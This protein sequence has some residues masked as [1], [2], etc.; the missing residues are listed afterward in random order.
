M[1]KTNHPHYA[2]HAEVYVDRIQKNS[3]YPWIL[4]VEG[5]VQLED[6][7]CEWDTQFDVSTEEWTPI[8]YFFG[9]HIYFMDVEA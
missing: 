9:G 4:D 8:R 7:G 2:P 5:T 6:G 1:K 3:Q